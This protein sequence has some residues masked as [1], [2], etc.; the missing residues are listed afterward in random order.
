MRAAFLF[1]LVEKI[2]V[3]TDFQFNARFCSESVEATRR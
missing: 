3:R 2:F 1:I